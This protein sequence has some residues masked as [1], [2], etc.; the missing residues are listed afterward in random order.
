MS[1][2]GRRVHELRRSGRRRPWA[3]PWKQRAPGKV[4]VAGQP[5]CIGEPVKNK[6]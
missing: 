2:V 4:V 1:I 3:T 5:D 6:Y